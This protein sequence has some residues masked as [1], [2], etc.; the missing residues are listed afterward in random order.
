MPGK[1]VS[2][3]VC[4]IEAIIEDALRMQEVSLKKAGVEVSRRFQNIPRCSVHESQLSQVLINL[5]KNAS[6][7]M[8]GNDN[9]NKR[10]VLTIEAGDAGD[11]FLFI[12]VRDT[13]CGICEEN[14]VR[15][16]NHGFSTKPDGHGFGLHTSALALTN[17]GG[18]LKADSGGEGQGA[19]F[20]L[21]LLIAEGVPV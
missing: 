9:Q 3:E 13:G 2:K 6:E 14:L 5:I 21:L 16:F 19:V 12:V 18:R 11:G 10:R 7:A 8:S 15:I 17:M 1:G 4:D 20:T